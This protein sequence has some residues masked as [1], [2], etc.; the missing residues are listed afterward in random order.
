MFSLSR[1][2]P[3]LRISHAAC[4][5][6]NERRGRAHNA[7]KPSTALGIEKDSDLGSLYG[8]PRFDELVAHAR[9]KAA[10]AKKPNE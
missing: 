7:H 9:E 5:Q 10:A 8:D 3:P 4:L 2:V 1:S 6:L